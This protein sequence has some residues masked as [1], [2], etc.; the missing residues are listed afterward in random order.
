[1]KTPG[2]QEAGRREREREE[3]Q[4]LADLGEVLGT[5]AGRRVFLR[6]LRELGADAPMTRESEMRLR[7]AADWILNRAARAHPPACLRIMAELRGIDMSPG[8]IRSNIRP[9][10]MEPETRRI[11]F[12]RE[13]QEPTR[14]ENA[15]D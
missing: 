3:R 4:A 8:D 7:N 1:M 2:D 14:K 10:G 13:D 15:H 9:D 5:E 12:P 11:T 6:L